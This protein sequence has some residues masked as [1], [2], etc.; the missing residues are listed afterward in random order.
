MPTSKAQKQISIAYVSIPDLQI[1]LGSIT[2]NKANGGD[3]I[4]GFFKS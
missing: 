3:G 1:G 4:L 2:T